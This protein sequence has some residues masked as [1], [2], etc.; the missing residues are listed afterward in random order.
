MRKLGIGSDNPNINLKEL[1]QMYHQLR[2]R[3]KNISKKKSKKYPVLKN[4][5]AKTVLFHRLTVD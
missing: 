2:E 5:A 4:S 3:I 1:R